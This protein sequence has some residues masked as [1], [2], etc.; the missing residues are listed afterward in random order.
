MHRTRWRATRRHSV[1]TLIALLGA[2]IPLAACG[3]TGST[4]SSSGSGTGS[5]VFAAFQPF[6]GPDAAFGLEPL[7]GCLAAA[8]AIEQAGGILNHRKI[9]CKIVDTRG[10]PADAVPAAEQMLATTTNLVGI[11]GPSSDEA[12]ATV[13]ILNRGHVPMFAVTGQAQFDHNTL[14]YFY[15]IVPPDDATGYAMAFLAHQKGYQ[16]AAAVFGNDISSQGAFP[17]V[18]SGFKHLGGKIVVSQT[19]PLDQSSYRTEVSAVVAAH[20]DV[21][22]TEADP[23]TN[24]TYFAELKQLGHLVTIM[25]TGGTTN[26]PWLKAVGDAIGKA[27]FS[28][29]YLGVQPYVPLTGP[30]YTQWSQ[31]VRAVKNQ[32]PKPASQWYQ[33]SFVIANWD[34]AN[35]MSL[36]MEEA[37]STNPT[38]FNPFIPKVTVASPG[39][40]VVHDF[41]EGKRAILAGKKIQYIG[42]TGKITFDKYHNSPGSFEILRSDGTT[43]VGTV[44]AAQL[45]TAEP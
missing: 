21:I 45:R 12:S 2:A 32:L 24:A 7:S 1:C 6:S 30:A 8:H 22:F 13:P 37:H 10:D 4:G 34:G 14:P 16:T 26:P 5:L 31:E 17:T 20:S 39:A 27:D 9:D 19:V 38:V 43:V 44:T 23:Q 3:S 25:G 18:V 40:V 28:K 11:L 29:Y 33:N 42:A 41:A 15:R 35:I 36:A